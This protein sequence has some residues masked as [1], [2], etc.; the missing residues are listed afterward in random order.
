[1]NEQRVIK[2]IPFADGY[3]VSAD[4]SVWSRRYSK[5]GGPWRK[6]SPG[7]TGTGYWGVSLYI[8]KVPRTFLV[9][10]LVLMT[11]VSMPP[12]NMEGLHING[13]PL[14]S[15]LENLRWGTRKENV[16]DTFRHGVLGRGEKSHASKLTD[17]QREEI[18]N[19]VGKQG[20][21]ARLYGICPSYV[22]MLRT[23]RAR[24]E[25]SAV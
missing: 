21:I 13:N 7:L 18:A 6:L 19:S 24:S 9:H 25:Q 8:N 12:P 23:W 11:F 20:P 5:N 2:E 14:D 17:K 16:A 3:G 1:M 22:S 15:R 10:R 4:G